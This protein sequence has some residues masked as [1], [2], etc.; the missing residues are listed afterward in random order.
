[1][2]CLVRTSFW[3]L[4]GHLL[5]VSS[6]CGRGNRM[7]WG[8]HYKGTNPIMRTPSL[9]PNHLPKTPPQIPSHWG[10]GFQ[11]MNFGGTH[12]V[13]NIPRFTEAS[14]QPVQGRAAL[15][16]LTHR[17]ACQWPCTQWAGSRG[18]GGKAE[19]SH[20]VAPPSP[21]FIIAK[22]VDLGLMWLKELCGPWQSCMTWGK[23]PDLSVAV[24]LAV[25]C[26]SQDYYKY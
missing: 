20:F 15:R 21:S 24:S 18:N 11:H 22:L 19:K 4:D 3:L 13:H 10:L 6:H 16:H 9:W 26:I 25:K 14:W 23:L 2:W 17:Q 7:L 8:L 5:T 1:M 12:S